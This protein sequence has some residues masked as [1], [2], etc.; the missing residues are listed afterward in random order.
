VLPGE[1][2]PFQTVLV[3]ERKSLQRQL[4][5]AQG[6][7]KHMRDVLNCVWEC[8][9]AFVRSGISARLRATY[10]LLSALTPTRGASLS[11]ATH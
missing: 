1:F 7:P 8:V 11:L 5:R 9:G 4:V 2:L 3:H 10:T 6:T